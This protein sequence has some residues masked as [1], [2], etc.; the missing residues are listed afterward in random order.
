MP[1]SPALRQLAVRLRQL[2]VEQSERSKLTQGDLGKALG[3]S[4]ATIASWENSSTP[5]LPQRERMLGYAQFFATPRSVAGEQPRLVPVDSFSDEEQ[6]TYEALTNEL[7]ALHDAARGTPPEPI[8]AGRSWHFAD[9]GP[10]TLICSRLPE[11]EGLS[12]RDRENPNYTEL[13]SFGD[14]DAMVELH[15]HARAENPTMDVYFKHAGQVVPDDLSGHLV[16]IGG[17]GW[18]EITKSILEL[19]RLPVTQDVVADVPTGEIFVA[20]IDG[21]EQRFLPRWSD[22]NHSKLME[23][24]G[25][26][27]RMPNPHNSN[28]T[29]T[30]CNGIHSPG[31]YGAARSL[32]DARLRESNER[33]IA[34]NFPGTQQFGILMRIQVIGGRAMTP[35]FNRSDTILYQWPDGASGATE[36][37]AAR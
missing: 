3:L 6:A 16:I 4:T 21:E 8:V 33:Y 25:L 24:V 2:R 28:R 29:L 13:L 7:L 12:L 35:D 5:K 20:N 36:S 32:T 14:L 22:A 17:I 37:G 11:S 31:V 9:S 27:V 34:R 23:D 1:P 10:M 19:I 26:L 15:G 18:N 30:M